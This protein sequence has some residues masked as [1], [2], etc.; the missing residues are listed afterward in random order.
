MKLL[1]KI[2]NKINPPPPSI[3]GKNIFVQKSWLTKQM[4]DAVFN[5]AKNQI[6]QLR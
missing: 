2:Y 1:K 3:Y 6:Y 4:E 5:Q